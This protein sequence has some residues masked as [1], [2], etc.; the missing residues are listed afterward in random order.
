MV[1]YCLASPQGQIHVILFIN[2]SVSSSYDFFEALFQSNSDTQSNLALKSTQN[3]STTKSATKSKGK[4]SK[5]SWLPGKQTSPECDNIYVPDCNASSPYR[6]IDGSCNNL[7]YTWWGRSR[8]PYKR[9]LYPEYDDHTADLPRIKSSVPLYHLPNARLVALNVFEVA[10][11]GVKRSD[12]SLLTPYFA[13]FVSYDI[14]STPRATFK[15]GRPK[16]CR[17]QHYDDD[18][19]NIQTPQLDE[20]NRDNQTCMTYTRSLSSIKEFD[21]D[22]G[23]RE[24]LDLATHWLDLSIIYGIILSSIP[25]LVLI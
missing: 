15:R 14:S 5:L 17:C 8:T 11:P 24:Q 10:E 18:C 21:C 16:L 9:L 22:I 23:P 12:S 6:T 13:E 1:L 19:F 25:I 7:D 4:T 2:L 20:I 3:S